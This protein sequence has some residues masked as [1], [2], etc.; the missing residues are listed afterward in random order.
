MIGVIRNSLNLLNVSS[1]MQDVWLG[2]V[3]VLAMTSQFLRRYLERWANRSEDT[4]IEVEVEHELDE[5]RRAI[6]LAEQ[7]ARSVADEELQAVDMVGRP[8]DSTAEQ[9]KEPGGEQ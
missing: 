2:V 8:T 7:S 6:E 1:N 9:P 5:E 4:A 3:F